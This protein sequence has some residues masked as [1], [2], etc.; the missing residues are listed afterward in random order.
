M[1]LPARPSRVYALVVTALHALATL[2]LLSTPLPWW[3]TGIAI[4][5]VGISLL[6]NRR[7][8]AR[9]SQIIW[10]RGNHWQLTRYGK[11]PERAEL[12]RI[13]HLSRWLV[14]IA[15]RTGKPRVHR[16]VVPYDALDEPTFRR[17]RVRLRIEGQQ[18]LAAANSGR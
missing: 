15:L 14:V 4:A 11:P 13:D 18:Y 3:Q 1:A 9:P 6:L 16:I 8:D 17:L 12:W 2:A 7:S 5:A 10:H